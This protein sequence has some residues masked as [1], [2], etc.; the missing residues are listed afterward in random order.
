MNNLSKKI[1]EERANTVSDNLCA[2]CRSMCCLDLVM[3]IEAPRSSKDLET[4]KWYLHFKHSFIFIYK[5]IWYHLI[6]SECRFLDKKNM[7][8]TN[9]EDRVKKCRDHK[10]PKCERYEKWYDVIFDS[11]SKLENYA[12]R[13]KLVKTRK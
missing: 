2:N 12:L 8:C 4:Y 5:N 3:E 10:A 6:K 13:N 9:Y 11:P 1:I 7:L